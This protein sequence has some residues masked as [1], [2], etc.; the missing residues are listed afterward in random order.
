MKELFA[1]EGSFRLRFS[2]MESQELTQGLLGTLKAGGEKFCDYFHLPL[3]AGSDPVLRSMGRLYDTGR[4]KAKVEQLRALF[5][6]VGI[7]ADIIAGYP[8]ET[9]KDFVDALAY[10]RGLAL[11][12]LHVF[13]FSAR[14]GTRAAALKAL[15]PG[16]VSGRSAELRALDAEL[17]AAYAASLLGKELT[18]LT[19]RNKDTRAL[20]LASNFVNAELPGPLK[21]GRLLRCRVTAARDGR[22]LAE[23]V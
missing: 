11:S 1:L 23:P 5:P 10:V 15:P 18:V 19:L 16:T 9:Q 21:T 12:G 14:P 8:S 2:S 13:S 7:Y 17:R 3:Q 20:A 6:G 22:C 4:Y